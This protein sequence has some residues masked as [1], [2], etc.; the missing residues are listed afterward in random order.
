[1]PCLELVVTKV[2]AVLYVHE[3]VGRTLMLHRCILSRSSSSIGMQM[4][5]SR[6]RV[7]DGKKRSWQC[8]THELYVSEYNT[9]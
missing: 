5:K 3:S 4:G 8:M 1:M 7:P 9:R 2:R 6:A